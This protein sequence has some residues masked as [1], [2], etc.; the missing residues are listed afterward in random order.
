MAFKRIISPV[1]FSRHSLSALRTA[2][3]IARRDSAELLILHVVEGPPIVSEWFPEHGLGEA[4]VRMEESARE[5]VDTLLARHSTEL[6]GIS[7][8]SAIVNG[9]PFVEVLK[10]EKTWKADLIVLGARGATS[11]DQIIFGSTAERVLTG[12]TCSVLVVKKD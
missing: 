3:E 5:A 7:V 1:D 8:S 11:L 12:S 4:M 2:I 9:V 6:E 10:Q